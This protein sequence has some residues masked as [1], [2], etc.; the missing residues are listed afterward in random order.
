V[1][2][3]LAGWRLCWGAEA[4]LKAVGTGGTSAFRGRGEADLKAVG[5][6]APTSAFSE[7]GEADIAG[8]AGTGETS[9]RI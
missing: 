1:L 9:A 3:H 8:P 7:W 6:G 4:D 2:C 5:T